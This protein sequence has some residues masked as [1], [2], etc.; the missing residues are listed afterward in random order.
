MLNLLLAHIRRVAD[1][2]IEPLLN[3]KHPLR[4]KKARRSILVVGVPLGQS[5]RH[6][7]SPETPSLSTIDQF[8]PATVDRD[9]D[10][11]L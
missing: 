7:V 11:F 5:I 1:T 3:P 9:R 8:L 6:A 4:V 2:N 10:T